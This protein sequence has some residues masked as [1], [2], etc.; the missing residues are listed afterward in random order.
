MIYGTD[1]MTACNY[2]E[3]RRTVTHWQQNKTKQ[4][5]DRWIENYWGDLLLI[6]AKQQQQVTT[7][8][9]KF[10]LQWL[11]LEKA[12]SQLS[13]LL[14]K[15]QQL[16][17]VISLI[18][19]LKVICLFN[20]ESVLSPSFSFIKANRPLIG[21]RTISTVFVLKLSTLKSDITFL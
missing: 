14:C 2:L 13:D 19:E 18:G 1:M 4:Q 8:S 10:K 16:N 3:I 9:W 20:M 12:I 11:Q 6:S 15:R 5:P 17:T 7:L 21:T